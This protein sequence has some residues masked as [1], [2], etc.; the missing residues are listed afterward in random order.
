MESLGLDKMLAQTCRAWGVVVMKSMIDQDNTEM[1][2]FAEDLSWKPIAIGYH[3]GTL[4]CSNLFGDKDIERRYGKGVMSV[5]VKE[6][7]PYACISL[8]TWRE[9]I[10]KVSKLGQ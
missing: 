7:Q 4:M 5:S 1:G 2:C 10:E 8:I 3:S 9:E 6:F